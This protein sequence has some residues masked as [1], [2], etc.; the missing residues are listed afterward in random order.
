MPYFLLKK[1]DFP[2]TYNLIGQEHFDSQLMNKNQKYFNL[3]LFP[4]KTI[5][6]TGRMLFIGRY[7]YLCD[8]KDFLEVNYREQKAKFSNFWYTATI[9]KSEFGYSKYNSRG[10]Q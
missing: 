8:Q 6:L 1:L 5:K 9:E 2:E 4:Y 3:A 10:L 7:S